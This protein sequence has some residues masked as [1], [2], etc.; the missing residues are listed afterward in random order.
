M[1][2]VYLEGKVEGAPLSQ[3]HTY[4]TQFFQMLLLQRLFLLQRLLLFQRVC[5]WRLHPHLT[6]HTPG[7][8][9]FCTT[10]IHPCVAACCSLL[11]YVSTVTTSRTTHNHT[12]PSHT[13]HNH[14]SLARTTTVTTAT[15]GI[16]TYNHTRTTRHRTSLRA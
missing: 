10:C 3:H 5:L 9:S 4:T 16:T 14:A 6:R 13:I 12:S 8:L 15:T 11:Q 2:D 7:G 1:L